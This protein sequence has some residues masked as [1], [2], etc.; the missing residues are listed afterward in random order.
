M[1]DVHKGVLQMCRVL[2]ASVA[3]VIGLAVLSSA[4]QAAGNKPPVDPD[5]LE[6]ALF[7][8]KGN[9]VNAPN[10]DYWVC[11][12]GPSSGT[13]VAAGGTYRGLS[14]GGGGDNDD[15]D[16]DDGDGKTKRGHGYGDTKHDHEW[17]PQGPK[18]K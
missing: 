15:D 6:W 3:A 12:K 17:Q 4:P 11:V 9:W 5:C 8:Y 10:G 7:K 1:I 16:D 14:G 13:K 18:K 2:F